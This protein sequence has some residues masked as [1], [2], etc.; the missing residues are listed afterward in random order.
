MAKNTGEGYRE[1]EVR[2]RSQIY[3]P[4]TKKWTKRDSDS[5]EFMDV[6]EDGECPKGALMGRTTQPQNTKF[7][8]IVT[9]ELAAIPKGECY[10]NM[11]RMVYEQAR[12]NGLGRRAQIA[13]TAAVAHEFA[14]RSVREHQPDFVPVLLG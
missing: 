14:L 11:Y 13:G 10:Q 12:L 2:D 6:K 4:V 3:N 5:G 7:S 8:T 9:E 1:G